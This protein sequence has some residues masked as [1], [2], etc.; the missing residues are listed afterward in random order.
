MHTQFITQYKFI[1]GTFV[2][3]YRVRR[4]ELP[5]QP[6]E[7]P[8]NWQL[9]HIHYMCDYCRTAGHGTKLNSRGEKFRA[10]M[11]NKSRYKTAVRRRARHV[12]RG[13]ILTAIKRGDDTIDYNFL[14][15]F[16]SRG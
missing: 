14:P 7:P 9:E 1:R 5:E 8:H 4:S 12:A 2:C 11:R 16:N 10:K 3:R 15:G 13:Y 6:A